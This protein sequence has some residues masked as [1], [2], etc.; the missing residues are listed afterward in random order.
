MDR[1]VFNYVCCFKFLTEAEE[2]EDEHQDGRSFCPVLGGSM[3]ACD[4]HVSFCRDVLWKVQWK[5]NSTILNISDRFENWTWFACRKSYPSSTVNSFQVKYP[6][7]HM[8][9]SSLLKSTSKLPV[10]LLAIP[11]FKLS[12]NIIF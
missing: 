6:Q 8:A 4:V 10:K 7:Y 11:L 1:L 9:I 3:F 12:K 2:Y 5:G